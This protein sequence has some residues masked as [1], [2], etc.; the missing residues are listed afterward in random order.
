M[1]YLRMQ[2]RCV[3]VFDMWDKNLREFSLQ[4]KTKNQSYRMHLVIVAILLR[5]LLNEAKHSSINLHWTQTQAHVVICLRSFVTNGI[6]AKKETAIGL[7]T[8][9]CSACNIINVA[10]PI[11]AILSAD[12]ILIRCLF[13][14]HCFRWATEIA[15]KN[16]FP[17]LF[18]LIFFFVSSQF[19]SMTL[20]LVCES[21]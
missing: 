18:H 9:S 13:G 10:R 2:S 5:A 19:R 7:G 8:R 16:V 12:N 15:A 21:M 20:S 11:V 14:S 1:S 4:L 6:F 3:C 17:I